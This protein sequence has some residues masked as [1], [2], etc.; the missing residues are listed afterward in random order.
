MRNRGVRVQR[1]DRGSSGR[2][3]LRTTQGI[4][5]TDKDAANGIVKR[6]RLLRLSE[7]EP[8][9]LLQYEFGRCCGL[10]SRGPAVKA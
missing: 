7:F 2:S 5:G 4:R 10:K 8:G 9:S 1:P 3:R 6:K